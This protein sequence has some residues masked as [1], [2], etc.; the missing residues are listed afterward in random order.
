MTEELL[1]RLQ[2]Q[3]VFTRCFHSANWDPGGPY[4]LSG[5]QYTSLRSSTFTLPLSFCLDLFIHLT[6]RLFVSNHSSPVFLCLCPSVTATDFLPFCRF[7]P[8]LQLAVY[9]QINWT[10]CFHRNDKLWYHAETYIHHVTL[11]D[12]NTSSDFKATQKQLWMWPVALKNE[13]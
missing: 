13:I 4:S 12:Q 3:A 9:L 1:T 10:W 5:S 7:I 11:G 6:L 8:L 2:P